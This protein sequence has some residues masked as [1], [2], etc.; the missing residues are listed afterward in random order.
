MPLDAIDQTQAAPLSVAVDVRTAIA[1]SRVT[2]SETALKEVR[3]EQ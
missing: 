2:S 3:S 1:L